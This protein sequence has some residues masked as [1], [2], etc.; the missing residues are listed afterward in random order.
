M[1]ADSSNYH[2]A[3]RLPSFGTG[4]TR[5]HGGLAALLDRRACCSTGKGR[6]ALR[7]RWP[8]GRTRLRAS[9]QCAPTL[10]TLVSARA[11]PRGPRTPA[12]AA[13]CCG[14]ELGQESMVVVGGVTV[15][16]RRPA[17]RR[18][19]PRRTSSTARAAIGYE[20][21]SGSR[22]RCQVEGHAGRARRAPS[23]NGSASSSCT[24][25]SMSWSRHWQTRTIPRATRCITWPSGTR[26]HYR[27][28]GQVRPVPIAP[29]LY[30]LSSDPP[31]VAIW[32]LDEAELVA[33]QVLAL[34][35]GVQA[36]DSGPG[37][38]VWES[39]SVAAADVHPVHAE[40]RRAGA[41]AGR[42][43]GRGRT[44]GRTRGG[45]HGARTHDVRR[46]PARRVAV[47][48]AVLRRRPA[49]RHGEQTPRPPAVK[50]PRWGTHGVLRRFQGSGV[51]VHDGYRAYGSGGRAAPPGQ[52]RTKSRTDTATP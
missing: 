5:R 47:L 16:T 45:R 23:R 52:P 11:R 38:P 22:Y 34:P 48:A 20:H 4:L 7:Q 13:Y 2:V 1:P 21:L 41:P 24:V 42:A 8:S 9:T 31:A 6:R 33:P 14:R 44:R 17:T 40:R 50:S 30:N 27:V 35:E 32:H 46:R 49:S 28:D 3:R 51:L 18:M 25:R 37:R 15:R 12:A 36:H 29:L 39:S 43:H 10:L 26:H 19:G